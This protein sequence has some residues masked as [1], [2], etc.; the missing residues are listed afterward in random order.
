MIG[1]FK[2]QLVVA[3]YLKEKVFKTNHNQG[4]WNFSDYI[5]IFILVM[6]QTTQGFLVMLEWL[7]LQWI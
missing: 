3:S 5:S 6:I 4:I 2:Q 7:E 1:W